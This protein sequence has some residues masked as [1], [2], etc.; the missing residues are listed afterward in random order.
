MNSQERIYIKALV[1]K[2]KK[3][4]ENKSKPKPIS[5]EDNYGLTDFEI[6]SEEYYQEFQALS[7]EFSG[8]CILQTFDQSDEESLNLKKNRSGD[9]QFSPRNQIIQSE[10]VPSDNKIFEKQQNQEMEGDNLSTGTLSESNK[11]YDFNI[12]PLQVA[13]EG[14]ID[15]LEGLSNLLRTVATKQK[16]QQCQKKKNQVKQSSRLPQIFKQILK[17][18]RT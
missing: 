13:Q 1:R 3:I 2:T 17:S 16:K 7:E 12:D 4:I 14:E 9:N 5:D 6:N 15:Y 11:C 8:K 10:T 18:S